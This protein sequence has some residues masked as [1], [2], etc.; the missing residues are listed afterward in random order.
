MQVIVIGGGIAGLAAAHRLL[1]QGH[2]VTLLESTARLGGKLRVGDI[3]GHL[4]V[5]LGAEAMLAR[6]PEAVGLAHAVGLGGDLRS[7]TGAGSAIWTRGALQPMPKGHLMG[8]PADPD[9]LTGIVSR[10]GRERMARDASLPAT[11]VGEDTA[12]GEYVARRLG[13]EVV[14]RLVEPLLGGVYA[15]DAYQ[16]SMRA[17]VP[18]LYEAARAERSLLTG[19]RAALERQSAA[20]EAGTAA[21]GPVF[22]GIEGGIGRLPQAVA[23]ACRSAGGT[24]RTGVTVRA[25]HRLPADGGEVGAAR[26]AETSEAAV[27]GWRVVT[28]TGETLDADAVIVAAPAPAAA[29]VLRPVAPGAATELTAVDYASMALVTMA[30]RRAE[31]ESVP[32]GSGFLVPPVDGRVIKAATFSANKWAWTGAQDPELFVLRASIGR[33][34]QAERL[35]RPDAELVAAARGDLRA[36]VGISAQPVATVVSRWEG[37]LPQY[38]VGHQDRV[39]RVRRALGAL[40]GL[41]VCGAA[42]DGVGIPACVGSADAAVAEVTRTSADRTSTTRPP[43]SGAS[44]G[45]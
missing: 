9:T 10:E 24:L 43:G 13:R 35:E 29:R 28:E 38:P 5:D 33:Y 4:A 2:F 8:V 31:C 15:G 20:R 26:Q 14:D 36:A 12:I 17:T 39:A 1:G 11:E 21:T 34:G 16:L 37:G 41:A 19:V 27:G 42:Y 30:F 32:E 44:A 22:Q 45:E 6:R 23:E 3:A 7:P 25:V 40:P 18:Q